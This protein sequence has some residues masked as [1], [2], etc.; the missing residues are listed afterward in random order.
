MIA[1]EA[2]T[3][4]DI[5]QAARAVRAQRPAYT[6]IVAYYEQLFAAQEASMAHIQVPPYRL[7]PDTL[8]IKQRDHFPL[9]SVT[10]FVIDQQAAAGLLA[11]LCRV[12]SRAQSELA[13]TAQAVSAAMRSDQFDVR[14]LFAAL[15]AGDDDIFVK[16]AENLTADAQGLAFLVYS[17][18]KPSLVAGARQLAAHLNDVVWNKGYC[19]ICGSYPGVAL[20]GTDGERWLCCGFCWHKWS[21]SRIFCSFCENTDSQTLSYYFSEDEKGY[22]VDVC[23]KCRKYIKTVDTRVAAHPIYPPLEQVSTLHLDMLAKEK[24]LESGLTLTFKSHN[25]Q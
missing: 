16:A 7:D 6:D 15:L 2:T 10:D 14:P 22:R 11:Q 21:V 25:P 12:T 18:M 13:T 23:D 20:L 19:P 5:E 8:G 1:N 17:A 9:L 24:G 3:P 4:A